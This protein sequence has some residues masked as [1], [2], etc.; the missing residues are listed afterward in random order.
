MTD[1]NERRESEDVQR[2]RA[3]LVEA[4]PATPSPM[5][6]GAEGNAMPHSSS[7]SDRTN[8]NVNTGKLF[9]VSFGDR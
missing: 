7:T 8:L 5:T 6:E 3:E 2:A 4:S 1:Q 9:S